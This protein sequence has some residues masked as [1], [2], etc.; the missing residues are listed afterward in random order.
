MRVFKKSCS[1]CGLE[2]NLMP[3]N[4]SQCCMCKDPLCAYCTITYP[5]LQCGHCAE[6]NV[7]QCVSWLMQGFST[8]KLKLCVTCLRMTLNS[9]CSYCVTERKRYDSR[10]C[11]KCW[12]IRTHS[13]CFVRGCQTFVCLACT[14]HN[15]A[16]L[17]HIHFDQYA[18]F[19]CRKYMHPQ[20][21]RGLKTLNGWTA[22]S[23]E[24]CRKG[25]ILAALFL[26]RHLGRDISEWILGFIVNP[27]G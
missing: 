27:Y 24:Q 10:V 17:C 15:N 25:W 2:P 21:N 22:R 8:V 26:R 23:C 3:L 4:P 11:N 5:I 7:E 20:H 6:K 12:D 1:R 16:P 18:C 9:E 13:K 14:E 19:T